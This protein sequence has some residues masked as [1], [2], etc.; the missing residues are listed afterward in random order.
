MP[1]PSATL[2]GTLF[3]TTNASSYAE[4]QTWTP[5]S[6]SLCVAFVCVSATSPVAPPS[7]AGHGLTW[8]A[9]TLS[10]NLISTTHRIDVY[11]AKSS[12][13]S[14]TNSAFTVSGYSN[15]PTGGVL[16]VWE[17]TNYDDSVS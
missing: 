3:S 7:V 6:K 12:G 16:C 2:R 13:A 9:L 17:I 8:T 11:V 14:P 1:S 5:G 15:S 10:A 4:T